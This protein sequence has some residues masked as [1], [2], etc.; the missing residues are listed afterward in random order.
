MES[1]AFALFILALVVGAICHYRKINPALPLI[2]TG[3]AFDFLIPKVISELPDPEFILTLVLAP[4]V[5]A[6]A[7][8]SS[9]LDLRR[10]R[11]SVLLL[12]VVLV[13]ITTAVVG[14]VAS[15]TLAALTFASACALGAILAPTDAVAASAVASKIG[16]PSRV[17]L[18]IEG[19]SLANDG[20]ALTILRVATVAA[21]AGSVTLM[22]GAQIL[23]LAVVGGVVVGAVGGW[24]VSLLI[25]IAKEPIVG[26]A[27]LL[28][29]PFV[30]Y[31]L[32]EEL[33]GSGLLTVVIAGVWI[34]HTTSVRGNFQLRLQSDSVW[35]LITFILESFA[36]VLVGAE[37]LD[38][39][40]R[41]G[42][43]GWVRLLVLAVGL[44]LLITLVRFGFMGIWFLIGPKVSPEK[45][46]DRRLAAKEFIAI[47]LL[48]VRGPI[49]VLAAFSI[50]VTTD[51]GE[52]FPGR[53]LIL[54]VTF[55]VV[56]VSLLFSFLGTPLI[57]RLN[58]TSHT[59]D[60]ALAAAR[61]ASAR[62]ALRR[63]DEVVAQADADGNPLDP[64]LVEELRSP[65]A[66]RVVALK[67]KSDETHQNAAGYLL[68]RE[69]IRL[70]M[71]EAEREELADLRSSKRIPG[72]VFG[73][74]TTELDMREQAIHTTNRGH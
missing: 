18:V 12:A 24:F 37:F 15:L 27:I 55:A 3:L 45:F 46:A 34:A 16:L 50:P 22:Q 51:S 53:D 2:A 28:L 35:K 59:D 67:G 31:H 57:R 71:I 8:A 13:V 14:V 54:C 38:T 74:L 49:S 36:F 73:Q 44:T 58:L 29:T 63:F 41:V 62:A 5:F 65:T 66:R 52:G 61:L 69:R 4:L 60:E 11:R 33:G 17:Q 9:A 68:T 56:I 70:S 72:D 48:G 1:T 20:T 10:I 7:L 25:R 47:G 43:P 6:A 32:S 23:L 21:V 40:S 39:Y 19:E 26:N 30:L 64:E 42:E